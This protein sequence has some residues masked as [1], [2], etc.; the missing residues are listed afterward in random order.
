MASLCRHEP[1]YPGA[2]G[3]AFYEGRAGWAVSRGRALLPPLIVAV[4][5]QRVGPFGRKPGGGNGAFNTVLSRELL[6]CR[7][8]HPREK[9][10]DFYFFLEDRY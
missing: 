5:R 8:C 7:A 1:R 3:R 2:A 4:L 10:F 9:P 6:F